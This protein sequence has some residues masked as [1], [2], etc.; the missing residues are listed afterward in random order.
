MGEHEM[1]DRSAFGPKTTT[2]EVL[3]GIDLSGKTVL[4]T[5]GSSGLGA[6]TA[7]AMAAKG[8]EVTITARTNAKGQPTVDQIKASTGKIISVEALELGST[9]SIHAFA[10]RINSSGRKIDILINNA[11]IMAC[12]QGT[13]DDGF[14]M[15]FGTNHL[16]H[17][18]MTCL[19]APSLADGGR[20]VVL[21]SS[22]HQMS[23]VMFDDI[24]MKK[25]GYE[26]WRSYGQSKTANALFAVGLNKR[27][28]PRN[29]EVFPVHPGVIGTGLTKHLRIR[30]FLMFI[31]LMLIGAVKRKSIPA[32]AA[33]Q[34]FAATAPEITG[35][36]GSYLADCKIAE[37]SPEKK[38]DMTVVWPYAL[39][40]EHAERLWS[41]SED[42]LGQ[43]FANL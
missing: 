28:A 23:D 8:A 2:D 31:P 27:L 37:I 36:G 12:P 10:D 22:A 16:G 4:I 41:M 17:F 42:M 40:P 24:D 11:G 43:K 34:C 18:L 32:G 19:I 9:K 35:K 6:E 3:D 21:S 14:E 7:R 26:R 25:G 29:I 33:S 13:T 20:I 1:V 39:N 5:G 15:Q 38:K 30:D